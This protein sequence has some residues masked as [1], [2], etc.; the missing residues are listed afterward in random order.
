MGCSSLILHSDANQP[1]LHSLNSSQVLLAKINS[2]IRVDKFHGNPF[3]E[4][5]PFLY[6]CKPVHFRLYPKFVRFIIGYTT[7]VMFTMA[8]LSLPLLVC[9]LHPA[10]WQSFN[11]RMFSTFVLGCYVLSYLLKPREWPAFRR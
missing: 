6:K 1:T 2:K 3:N 9:F 4:I 5:Y 8:F 10:F 11:A 7:A